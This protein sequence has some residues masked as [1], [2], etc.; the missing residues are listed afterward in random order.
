MDLMARQDAVQRARLLKKSAPLFFDT[1]TTGTGPNA[2]IIELAIL[3]EQ[4]DLL[5]ESL[6]RPRG[7]I[8]V[9]AFQV[10]G[11]TDEMV[12]SAPKW[13]EIWT[14]VETILDDRLLGAYNSDFDLRM[15]KQSY[16]FSMLNWQIP[17]ERFFCVMKLYARFAGNWDAR[18]RSYRWQS[19]ESA[20][21]QCGIALPNSHR[22]RDDAQLAQAIFEY[23][24]DWNA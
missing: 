8:E 19:L 24:A 15:L 22:A 16:R 3:D 4:G 13:E 18:R 14:E 6:V 9:G 2:E 10:H 17:D 1:E 23:I 7:R 21:R 5:F 20:G 11:I 12:Q